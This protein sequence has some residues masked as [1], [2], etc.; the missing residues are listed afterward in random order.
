MASIETAPLLESKVGAAPAEVAKT[1]GW[2]TST[3]AGDIATLGAGTALA[4]AFNT[5]LVFLIPRLMSVEE[6]GYWRLFL[7]Y[8][9]YVGFLHFGFAD[10]ALLRWAGK[11]LEAIHHEVG[12]SWK[13]LVVQHV[14]VIL[15]V[16]AVLGIT[17]RLSVHFRIVCA[18][19][20]V[21][22]L[23]MNSAT[24][25]QYSLQA[26][27][28]FR[29]VAIA[30]AVPPGVFVV[31]ASCWSLKS[32]PTANELMALYG[33]AWL[34]VLIYLWARVKPQM[35]N[36]SDV[37]WTLGKTLTVIGWPV[38]M[39]N[40]GYGLVQSADRLVV[41]S[42]LPITQFAQYSMAAS[43]MFV[44]ITAIAAVSRVFFAHAAAVE[45]DDR[46]KIYRHMSRFLLIAWSLLLPYFFVLE[47]FVKRFLP[48]YIPSLPVAGILIISVIFLAGIQIL[49]M[50]Y[51][52]LYGKQREFLYRTMGALAL[53][54]VVA[55]ALTK[56]LHSLLAVAI[57]QVAALAFW[58]MVNEWGL[59]RTT[60]QSRKDWLRILSVVGWSAVSYGFALWCTPDAGW[61]IPIYYGLVVGVLWLSCPE[62]FRLGWRL[63]QGALLDPL[64]EQ[65]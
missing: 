19:V 40:T 24:L 41:S 38:V 47:A 51:F 39:A 5:M 27:R 16:C 18:G 64:N 36:S 53:S 55:L 34:V 1:E 43:A 37:A 22:G 63:L 45:H 21:F 20:L 57:G 4:A 23:I 26:G 65:C 17:P 61:R 62:E 28:V 14:V 6:Y 44:P 12:P 29:P 42:A 13:Y 8:A 31:L 10:G 11:T 46:A 7:L 9:G 60:G 49:H 59:R 30:A 50:N 52:Y 32:T 56:C 15:A 3:I 48:K 58:W 33:I 54:F 35:A 25:L 2:K